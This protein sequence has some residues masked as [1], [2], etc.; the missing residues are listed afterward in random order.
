MAGRELLD[1]APHNLLA[2]RGPIATLGARVPY[3][4][5]RLAVLEDCGA[6]ATYVANFWRAGFNRSNMVIYRCG[7]FGPSIYLMP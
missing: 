3:K 6:N 2:D 4:T 7:G 5:G 1:C